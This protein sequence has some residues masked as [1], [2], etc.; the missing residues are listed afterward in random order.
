MIFIG[1]T[2]SI[3]MGKTTVAGMFVDLGA[4]L[5]DADAAVH[6]LYA[7]GGA[8]VPL[9]RAVFPDVVEAGV[10]VREKL[11]KHL[12]NDP[13]HLQVLESFIH[14]MVG[15]LRALAIDAARKAGKKIMVFDVPLLFETEGERAM[16]KTIVVS[17]SLKVQKQR[18]LARPGMNVKKLALIL[19]R[20]MPDREKR[21]RADYVIWTDKELDFTRRDVQNIMGDLLTGE[22]RNLL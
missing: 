14:P 15:E 11:A 9:L 5:F 20:Q 16:D 22:A 7:K 12:Q 18:V 1:L 17:A 10:V 6:S 8:A 13:L 21:K 2:G 3:G 19:S 4:A